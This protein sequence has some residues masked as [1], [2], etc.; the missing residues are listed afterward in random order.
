MI[1]Y[2]CEECGAVYRAIDR[3]DCAPAPRPR[4]AGGWDVF[5]LTV[6]ALAAW[7]LVTR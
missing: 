7:W 4:A 6:A 5:L 2:Q 3:H 1:R